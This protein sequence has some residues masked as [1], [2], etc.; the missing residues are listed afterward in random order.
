MLHKVWFHP[1]CCQ[2]NQ[3]KGCVDCSGKRAARLSDEFRDLDCCNLFFFGI[4]TMAAE[5]KGISEWKICWNLFLAGLKQWTFFFCFYRSSSSHPSKASECRG[6]NKLRCIIQGR[7][8]EEGKKQ[9]K[10]AFVIELSSI[11]ECVLSG[12]KKKRSDC[13]GKRK[14]DVHL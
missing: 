13:K 12:N 1:T 14:H 3:S 9:P 4:K 8:N 2:A 5:I 7:T 6:K 11:F 10:E